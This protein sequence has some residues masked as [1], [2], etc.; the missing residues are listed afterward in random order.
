M[1]PLSLSSK[2][3]IWLL[4]LFGLL[5]LTLFAFT[6]YTAQPPIPT[7]CPPTQ[8]SPPAT[9]PTK[10]LPLVAEPPIEQHW[11]LNSPPSTQFVVQAIAAFYSI[12]LAAAALGAF[13]GLLLAQRKPSGAQVPPTVNYADGFSELADWMLKIIVG[14]GLAQFSALGRTILEK[15]HSLAKELGM[16]AGG[17]QLVVSASIIFFFI[18]GCL[19]TYLLMR[20][21][22]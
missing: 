18:W 13:L 22:R 7:P 14:A 10:T 3:A 11:L 15:S 6:A 5:C 19:T 1:N 20:P 16:L 4:P 2:R 12:A 17:T 9:S 8:A 21:L